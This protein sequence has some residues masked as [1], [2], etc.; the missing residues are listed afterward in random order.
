MNVNIVELDWPRTLQPSGPKEDPSVLLSGI[1]T[2]GDARHLVYALRIN[3]N[4]LEADLRDDL[5]ESVY[6]DYRLDVMLDE[7]LFFST[8][9]RTSAVLLGNSYYLFWMV[10]CSE[11]T[12]PIPGI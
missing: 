10:P 7:I 4:T 11:R 1:G 5:D 9:D 3:L 8:F 2:L 12:L 6:T